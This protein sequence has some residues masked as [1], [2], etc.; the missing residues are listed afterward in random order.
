VN[1]RIPNALSASRIAGAFLLLFTGGLNLPFFI[2]FTFCSLTDI[3]DGRIARRYGLCTPTGEKLDSLADLALV[4]AMLAVLIPVSPWEPWMIGY[5]VA[6]AAVR[7]VSAAVGYRK[8]GEVAL[9]HTLMNK[10]GGLC[11]RLAPYLM[12]FLDLG[13]IVAVVCTVSMA[14]AFEELAINIRSDSLDRNLRSCLELSRAP[15]K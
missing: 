7:V 1:P 9:I 4:L 8:Y 3:A 5:I 15:A 13:P 14:A 12:L 11:I 2:I 6:V 10:A